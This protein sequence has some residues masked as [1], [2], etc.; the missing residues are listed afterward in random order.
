MGAGR[1]DVGRAMKAPVT[2]SETAANFAALTA[3]PVHAIDLNIP[4]IN[5]PT[6][7]GRITTDADAEERHREEA[8]RQGRRHRRR[9]HVDHAS[10]PSRSPSRPVAAEP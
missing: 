3:D 10:A 4:S 1:V 5:A 9:R 7:P 2:I 6:M 8:L